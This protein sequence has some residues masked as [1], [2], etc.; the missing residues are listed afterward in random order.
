[1]SLIDK[2]RIFWFEDDPDAVE[3][4][5]NQLRT[6]YEINIGAQWGKILEERIVPF[7]LVII[8]LMIHHKSNNS[9]TF[10]NLDP[11]VNYPNIPNS[12]TTGY[13]NTNV[14]YPGIHWTETGVEFLKRLRKGEYEKYG[15]IKKMPAIVV[16]G[17][18]NYQA[19]E[20][21]REIG[22]NGFHEK[23]V[24]YADLIKTIEQILLSGNRRNNPNG[25]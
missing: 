7:D 9:E 19:E 16:T 11:I 12:E 2:K 25:K 15:F 18:G 3:E 24:L 10:G 20:K 23:P 14:S 13:L 6:T 1:M 17:V 8:D 21:T 4:Y 5:V 22:I